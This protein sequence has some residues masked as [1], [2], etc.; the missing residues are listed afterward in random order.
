[1]QA[2]ADMLDCWLRGASARDAIARGKAQ[3]DEAA[4]EA[5]GANL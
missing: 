4:H 1:M 2:W 3:I 5:E